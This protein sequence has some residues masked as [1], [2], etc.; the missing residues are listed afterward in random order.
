MPARPPGATINPT[1]GIISWT[2]GHA[3]AS[4]TNYINV[5]VTDTVNPALNISET[6]MVIVSDYLEY[7]AWLH[8]RIRRA[9]RQ[10]AAHRGRQRFRNQCANH[11][12][13]AELTNYSIRP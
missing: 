7:P 13:L 11:P 3:Y 12:Q 9:I 4:T 2:P 8:G 1:N 10:P 5:Y 6:V